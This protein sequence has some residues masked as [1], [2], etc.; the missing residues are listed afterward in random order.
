MIALMLIAEACPKNREEATEDLSTSPL[1]FGGSRIHDKLRAW[2]EM[3]RGL[4]SPLPFGGSRI[5]DLLCLFE[6]RLNALKSP[7]PFG[8]SRIH[9]TRGGY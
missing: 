5:H 7:L 9:D 4:R 2:E 1:P 8:G 3:T 6:E